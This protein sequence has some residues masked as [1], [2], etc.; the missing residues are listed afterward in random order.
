MNPLLAF[1][2]IL[3]LMM[4]VHELGHFI[5]ARLAGITVQ[6]FGFG[7]PPRLFGIRRGGV[8]YSINLIPFGAFVKMLGEEDP[9]APGSF[10]SKSLGIRAIVLAAGSAMN[11]A[12][13]VIAFSLVYIV[14]VPRLS[15]EGPVELGGIAP[16][17]PAA[18]AGLLQGDV[19]VGVG[20]QPTNVG[21]F[22]DLTQQNLDRPM[23]LDVRRGDQQLQVTVTPRSNPPENQGAIGVILDAN[24]IA[25]LAPHVAIASGFE[26]TVRAIGAT[27]MIPKLLIDGAIQPA[28]ARLIGLPNM[29]RLTSEAVDYAVDTGFWY[30]VFILT[31]LFSAGLSIANLLPIPALD[32]GRLFFVALEWIRGRRV[33]PEREAAYHFVGIVVLLTLMAIITFN[34]FLQ[35]V[36]AV[37]W[38]PR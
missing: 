35:P 7:L 6:E 26:Q 31:G 21:T 29:A 27:L 19:I 24:E 30:P 38:G 25:R 37:N 5:T 11:F 13:A 3:S 15:A 34:D 10:A 2:P 23:P 4:F 33:P 28:D 9:T 32:G 20:G 12:L 1:L 36:P 22:R 18:A 16:E 17:S 14:G 8:I